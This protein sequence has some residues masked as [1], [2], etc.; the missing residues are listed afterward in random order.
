MADEETKTEE[1]TEEEVVAE[2]TTTGEETTEEIVDETPSEAEIKLNELQG[3]FDQVSQ[4]AERNRELLELMASGNRQQDTQQEEE[5]DP[6]G[7]E[8]MTKSEAKAFEKRIDEKIATENFI[9]DFRGS[10]PDLADKGPKEEIVRYHFERAKGTFDERLKS[11]VAATK[12]LFQSEQEKGSTKTKA[13]S[14]KAAKEVKAK[15][16]AAAK[17]SGLSSAGKTPAKDSSEDEVPDY[18]AER[19]ARQ[20]KQKGE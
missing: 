9:R 19:R 5:I 18:A 3:K 2:E 8:F 6:D 20:R 15:A 4:D 7:D 12:K 17:A 14:E 16:E 11:A 13:E 1:T 10:N